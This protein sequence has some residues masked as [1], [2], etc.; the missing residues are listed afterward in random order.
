MRTAGDPRAARDRGSATAELALGLPAV[1]LALLL[2]LVAG[3]A[4]VAQVRCT[5]AARAAARAAALGEDPGVVAAI[6]ADLAGEAAQVAVT[7]S[8]GWVEVTVTRPVSVGWLGGALTA[9][10]TFAIPVEPDDP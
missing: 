2:V 7:T 9:S 10:A 1:V 4:A 8:G 3:S 5:D 6:V